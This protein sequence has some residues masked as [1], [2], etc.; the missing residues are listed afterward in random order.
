M[1]KR[2]DV[3]RVCALAIA[4]AILLRL[5]S[6]GLGAM[7]AQALGHEKMASV[8]LYLGTG[9]VACPAAPQEQTPDPTQLTA[10]G[11]EDNPVEFSPEDGQ[12]IQVGN[13]A[14]VDVD[15]PTLLQMPLD[16]D[17]TEQSPTV[18]ILHTHG[19]ESYTGIPQEAQSSGYRSLDTA[20]NMVSMGDALAE[21]LTQA[22]IGVIHDRTLYD[23]PSYNDAYNLA[24]AA[25]QGYLAQYPSICLVIDLHRDAAED[26]AG[27]QVAFTAQIAGQE[28]AQLMIVTGSGSDTLPHPNWKENLALALKL[29]VQLEKQ[30]P[31]LCRPLALRAQRYNQDLLPGAILVEVG[32]AGNTWDQ[33]MASIEPLA[34]SILTLAKGTEPE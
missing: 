20:Y 29:Q 18:L 23:Y 12:Q 14:G 8:L 19:S 10:P 33:A 7:V 24:R 9:R 34:R 13:F 21:Y 5:A 27:N 3:F 28:M 17:L 11:P 1:N 2:P 30:Y 6:G 26:A 22:G 4:C 15:I 31:G 25:I 16:W 32:T